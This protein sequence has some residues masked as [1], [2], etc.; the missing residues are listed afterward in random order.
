[1]TDVLDLMAGGAQGDQAGEALDAVLVIEVPLLVALDGV[2]L[3]AAAAD[4]AA[5]VRRP[6]G[7]PSW[8][9]RVTVIAIR[10]AACWLVLTR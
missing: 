5:V 10:W 6:V 9:L 1:V 2:G 3:A 7:R 8:V 4:L